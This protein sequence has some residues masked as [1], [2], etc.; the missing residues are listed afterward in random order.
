MKFGDHLW[1]L[2]RAHS[3]AE[4]KIMLNLLNFE[5]DPRPKNPKY[6]S[7][8]F[9]ILF[10]YFMY[11]LSKASTK[12]PLILLRTYNK[13]KEHLIKMENITCKGLA[14]DPN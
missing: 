14:T 11:Y 3:G 4:L 10:R 6:K 7:N 5:L 12:I 2:N 9:S 13:Y 8:I 1:V